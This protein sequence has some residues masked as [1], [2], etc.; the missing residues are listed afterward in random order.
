MEIKTAISG[1][2][3]LM[4]DLFFSIDMLLIIRCNKLSYNIRI[5]KA[6]HVGGSLCR[7]SAEY[8][9][10]IAEFEVFVKKKTVAPS[11]A[12]ENN[13]KKCFYG[14]L[15]FNIIFI[16]YPSGVLVYYS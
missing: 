2:K 15:C 1:I 8:I 16:D 5:D 4:N 13:I 11:G 10:S 9:I 7:Y 6:F 14:Y 12:T 3:Y